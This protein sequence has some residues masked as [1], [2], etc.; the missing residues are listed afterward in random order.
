LECKRDLG[1]RIALVVGGGAA[2]DFIRAM[3]RIHRLGD[4]AAHRLAIHALDLSA[5][6]LQ[7]LLPGSSIVSGPVALQAAWDRREFPILSPRGFLEEL[8]DGR[9]DALLASWDVTT[10]SIAARIAVRLG[11]GRLV[12]IKSAVLPQGIDRSEAAR[13]GLVD[14]M[15]PL[16][17]RGLD[18]VDWVSIR[19]QPIVRRILGS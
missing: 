13:L 12:L 4:D 5:C 19:H 14:A 18:Q 8:D 9:P 7:S 1:V 11:A 10:D 15:F 3:D 6:V 16:V 17:A 2:A